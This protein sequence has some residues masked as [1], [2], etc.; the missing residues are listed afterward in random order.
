LGANLVLV[1]NIQKARD[2]RGGA[3]R[4]RGLPW[5][6][7]TSGR[8][9]WIDETHGQ[10]A[11]LCTELEHPETPVLTEVR[12][13]ILLIVIRPE[14]IFQ[15]QTRVLRTE[16]VDN[17]LRVAFDNLTTHQAPKLRTKYLPN[18]LGVIEQSNISPQRP[19]KHHRTCRVFQSRGVAV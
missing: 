12:G 3:M 10:V 15:G 4:R 8:G 16:L 6:M 2:D 7:F 5:I 13:L 18:P 14:T 11:P 19:W 9:R 1:V 17:V